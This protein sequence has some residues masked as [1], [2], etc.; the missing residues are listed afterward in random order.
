MAL[1]QNLNK[2][3]LTF[4]DKWQNGI[5]HIA[6]LRES[7]TLLEPAQFVFFIPNGKVVVSDNDDDDYN[8]EDDDVNKYQLLYL[9][10]QLSL[11]TI[12]SLV[13]LNGATGVRM[14]N[15]FPLQH[16]HRAEGSEDELPLHTA[17]GSA[18]LTGWNGSSL[19]EK[20]Y[21]SSC[22]VTVVGNWDSQQMIPD[23]R[24]MRAHTNTR[25]TVLRV[26]LTLRRLC[27]LF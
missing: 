8:D 10:R 3:D 12:Q 19:I 22:Y 4:I 1:R 18:S 26:T 6:S 14:W 16:K 25:I 5:A 24:H 23:A 27:W 17:L 21:H 13:C 9:S 2:L 20:T 11:K 15:T 7:S